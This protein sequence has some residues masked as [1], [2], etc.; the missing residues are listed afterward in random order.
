MKGPYY[1]VEKE[2]KTFLVKHNLRLVADLFNVS[3]DAMKKTMPVNK[4]FVCKKT[5][6][7]VSEYILT[8]DFVELAN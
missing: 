6:I 2:G 3:Y 7:V 4:K 5:G 8:A 1:K